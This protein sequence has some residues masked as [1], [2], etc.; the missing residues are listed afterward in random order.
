[1]SEENCDDKCLCGKRNQLDPNVVSVMEKHKKRA[2]VGFEKYGVDTTR[3]DT[4]LLGW[5][6][7]LQ[8]ELMDAN[9]YIERTMVEIREQQEALAKREAE[10]DE[11]ERRLYERMTESQQG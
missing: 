1:M 9:V 4:D 11:R 7:H 8:E 6:N 2:E 5:L 3:T 10:L